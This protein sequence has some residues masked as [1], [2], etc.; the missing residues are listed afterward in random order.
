VDAPGKTKTY[1]GHDITSQVEATVEALLTVLA[2]AT[3]GRYD[4][5][6]RV[7]GNPSDNGK[8]DYATRLSTGERQLIETVGGKPDEYLQELAAAP[9]IAADPA[10]RAAFTKLGDPT[11]ALKV[12]T[13]TMHTEDDPLVI[14]QNES[15]LATRAQK[16]HA[17]GRL[18]QLYV[19]PPATYPESSGAPYGAGHC[20]FTDQQRLALVSTLD[21]WVRQSVYPVPVGVAGSFGAGLDAAY[22]SAPWP[23]ATAG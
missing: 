19:A 23:A 22:A 12:P 13:L 7:G 18:V 9:R 2:Y 6:K 16:Q 17:A 5:E 10:A 4:I 3:A 20:N 11:G 1:D 14:V 21:S 15:V 8:T